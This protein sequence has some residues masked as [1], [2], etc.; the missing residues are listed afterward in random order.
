V[1]PRRWVNQANPG[2]TKL[3]SS[4]IRH[5]WLGDLSEIV[6]LTPFADDAV[7]RAEFRAVKRDNKLRLAQVIK[8]RVGVEVNVDSLFDVQIKRIHEYKRQ[9][10]NVLHIVTLY[11]ELRS[12]NASERVPRTVIFGGKAAPGYATAKLII[13]LIHDVADV[14]NNDPAVNER[15]KVVF[16]PNYDVS[17]AGDII[18]A[19]DLSEQISTVGTEASGTGNM[20][21][22]LNGALTIGTLDGA[23]VEMRE[24]VG[25]ENFFLFGLDRAGLAALR[26]RGYTA[27][28][29]YDSNP[30]LRQVLDMI[31]S[32]F[33]SPGEPERYRPI[34]DALLRHG[35]QYL[36]LA[37]YADYMRAQSEVDRVYRDPEEWT[38]QA[39]LN[40]S[41]LARF[42]SDR[43]I[44]EYAERI[45]DVKRVERE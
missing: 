32:G 29:Y 18:P 35:D 20:K 28:E 34:I 8:A 7:F 9:L 4:R 5:D 11:N 10:L 22:S 45:W 31:G 23:N 26:E 15:L 44:M 27:R 3:I 2:L 24:A 21:L 43:T 37:D 17:T 1:T 25:A 13:R 12:G 30:Q 39:I 36:L 33:F 42:S 38:R 6:Q 14:V 19:A 16:I 40:V 41:R